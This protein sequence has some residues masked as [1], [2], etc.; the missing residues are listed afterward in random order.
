MHLPSEWEDYLVYSLSA[1]WL[2]SGDTVYKKSVLT[3]FCVTEATRT[4]LEQNDY[5]QK[6]SCD[7]GWHVT[8]LSPL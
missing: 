3:N 6:L 2:N 7:F 1:L 8:E 5:R 4:A